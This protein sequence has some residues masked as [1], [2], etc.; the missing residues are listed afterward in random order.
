MHHCLGILEH[1]FNSLHAW[2]TMSMLPGVL[3]V[4]WVEFRLHC[5]KHC[6]WFN[7][8]FCLFIDLFFP[9]SQTA[10]FLDS[11]FSFS[12]SNKIKEKAQSFLILCNFCW[13][14]IPKWS[15]PVHLFHWILML[16][17]HIVLNDTA[18]KG[19]EECTW[20]QIRKRKNK[21]SDNQILNKLMYCLH[22]HHY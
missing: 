9:S 19:H 3:I 18:I 13:F 11:N 21:S 10:N 4:C 14:P 2:M 12:L 7:V 5:V 1:V 8:L 20:K 17:L 15:A 22:S 6:E 16:N